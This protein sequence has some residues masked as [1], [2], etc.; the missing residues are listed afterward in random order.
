MV[1]WIPT[2]NIHRTELTSVNYNI[3]MSK[4][5]KIALP[6][7]P[8]IYKDLE[9]NNNTE[10]HYCLVEDTMHKLFKFTNPSLN[11]LVKDAILHIWPNWTEFDNIMEK[12][13][14][15]LL[16]LHNRLFTVDPPTSNSRIDTSVA[17][18]HK[19]M[20]LAEDRLKDSPNNPATTTT[21]KGKSGGRKSLENR[22]YIAVTLPDK[23]W[24]GTGDIKTPQALACLKIAR[25][26]ATEKDGT[27]VLTEDELRAAIIKRAEEIKTRQDPWRIFQYYRASLVQAGVLKH[28]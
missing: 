27:M 10:K 16:A 3:H 26:S 9:L 19:M 4:K 22:I 6:K 25:E 5:S 24:P 15:T 14:S 21:G 11:H 8:E 1:H 17:V 2:N 20:S 18:W 12:E 7:T 23:T 28:D 13:N